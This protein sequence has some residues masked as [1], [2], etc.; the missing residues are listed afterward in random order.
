MS[1]KTV[2]R[3]LIIV[4][5]SIGMCYFTACNQSQYSEKITTDNAEITES[6]DAVVE[7]ETNDSKNPQLPKN[8]KIIKSAN[9]KYKVKNV[10]TATNTIKQ[11]A[12]V[13]NAYIS[14][15]RFENSLYSLEN[16]FTVK[17]PQEHFDA[18]MDSIVQV[19]DF[20]DY[21][22]IT[23]DNVTEQYIDLQSRLKTK[24]EVKERYEI[25]LRKSAKTVKDILA[26][27]EKLRVIQEEIEA[28]QGKLKYLTN[29]VAYSTIQID[30]YETV[31]YK[32]EPETYSKSFWSK[33]KDALVFGWELVEAIVLGIIYIW[34]LLL[35]GFFLTFLLRK[36][37]VKK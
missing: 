32:E 3:V 36:R 34:P 14:D 7:N 19:A 17:I 30:L 20:I 22:N 9:V 10:K 33:S 13:F 27:E 35:I 25:I 4:T 16:R 6:Y 8:L 26:T 24:L 18:M 29:K 21:E 15:L 23:T 12:S 37:F 5:L 28:A 2:N 11:S 1:V 31:D